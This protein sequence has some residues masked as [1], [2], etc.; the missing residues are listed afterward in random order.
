MA[1]YKSIADEAPTDANQEA[2]KKSLLRLLH[3][4]TARKHEATIKDAQEK[5]LSKTD[6]SI[7][8][9][10]DLAKEGS[11]IYIPSGTHE[12]VITFSKSITLQGADRK[13]TILTATADAPLVHIPKGKT[14]VLAS[15]TIKSQVE[16]SER[17]DP[18]GCAIMAKDSKLIVRDCAVIALG[19]TKRCPLGIFVQGFAKV[20]LLDCYVEGYAYPIFYGQGAEGIVKGCIVKNS[21]DCG[22]MSHAES[23]VTIEGNIFFGSRKHG[24]R[25]TGGTLHVKDNLIIKNRNRGIYLGNKTAHGE[26]SNNAIVGNGSGISVFASSDVEIENNVILG[27][28]FSGIDTRTSGRIIVKNNIIAD[29]EKTGFA[30]FEEGSTKFKVGKNTFYGNG[31]PSTDFDLPSA[32]LEVDPQFSDADNGNFSAGNKAVKSAEHGLTDPGI[33]STL[34]KKYEEL[35]N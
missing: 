9:L 27:N 30:V 32:T 33:I 15:L 6:I 35:A 17:I 14:V 23:E 25:S 8:E 19:N 26:I 16:T 22:F 18:P 1:L 29:N 28:G 12:G 5:L 21:G 11:V 34:W 10:V 4:G 7:Q 24:I 31:T 3:I 20:Q 13:S 2:I